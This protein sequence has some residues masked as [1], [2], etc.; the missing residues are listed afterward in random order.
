MANLEQRIHRQLLERLDLVGMESSRTPDQRSI[1]LLENN[2]EDCC[3]EM[4]VFSAE[5]E[6]LLNNVVGLVL[7]DL[8]TNQIIL[9]GG[10]D[11]DQTGAA[12]LQRIR[13]AG[14]AD[15]GTRNRA[16]KPDCACSKTALATRRADRYQRKNSAWSTSR[17]NRFSRRF[18]GSFTPNC[19]STSSCER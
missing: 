2:I 5:N 3:R 11:G 1:L 8:L 18:N 7:R 12:D 13:Y 17:P 16:A 4:Q 6:D 14:H 9:E 19:E 15:S 10:Q